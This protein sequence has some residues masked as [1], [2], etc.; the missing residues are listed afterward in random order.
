VRQRGLDVNNKLRE[1][2]PTLMWS[3]RAGEG[4]DGLGEGAGAYSWRRRSPG[5]EA[6]ADVGFGGAAIEEGEESRVDVG[7]REEKGVA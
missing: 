3:R 1:P 4:I 5:E 2:A 6:R 7:L